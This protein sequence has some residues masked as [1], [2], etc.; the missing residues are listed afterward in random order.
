[1]RTGDGYT[2]QEPAST[3]A[4]IAAAI[5]LSI[6]LALTGVAAIWQQQR[7]S[8]DARSL[9]ERQVERLRGDLA[10]RLTMPAYGLRGA[11][12]TLAALDGSFTRAS[13]EAYVESRE[14]ASEF[15]GARGFGFI[16]RVARSD[17]SAFIAARQRKGG[18]GFRV[19][20]SG[21]DP[22]LYVVTQI[23]PFSRNFAAW[24]LDAGGDPTRRQAIEQAIATGEATLSAPVRLVQDPLKG[25]GLLLFV[26]IYREGHDPGTPAKRR[27]A[28]TGLLYAPLVANELL[29]GVAEPA[30]SL[31]NLKLSAQLLDGQFQPLLAMR[32]GGLLPPEDM[33]DYTLADAPMA[34]SHRFTV[35]GREFQLDVALTQASAARL[36]GLAG[37]GLVV[38]GVLLSLLLAVTVYLLAAGRARAERMARAMTAD[39]ARL[40]MVASHTTNAVMITDPARRITWVNEG[41]TRISGYTPAE[42]LGV[43]PSDLLHSELT[44]ENTVH[45][46][47]EAMSV[48]LGCQVELMHRA[49][50][51]RDYWVD[52]EIQ[53]LHGDDG[54]LSG[55][56]FI[57]SDITAR[58]TLQAQADEAR[59]SLLD[60]YDNAPC[61]YYAL[62]SHGRF[63][64]I[65][66]LGQKWLGC[67]AEEL[68]G[69]ASP[70][71]FFSPESQALFDDAFPRFK[72]D[73]RV[74]E[75]EFDLKGRHGEVRRV[76]LSA[77]AIYAADGS[78]LRSRS[79]MFDITETHRIR[80]QLHQLT[81]NQEAMLES[82]L[83]GIA[84]MQERKIVWRNAALERMFGYAE[85][86]L[87][88][89]DARRLY[90]DD[91][92]YETL[93]ALAYPQLRAGGRF[94]TQLQM[95]RRDGSLI[96][97]DLAGV[98]LPALPGEPGGESLWMMVDITQSKAHE[99]RMEHAALHDALTGLPNRL[100][101]AD[102]LKQAIQGSERSGHVFALA[103]LDLNGFKQINDTHGHD[104]G[105]E[106]LKAVAARLQGGLRAG[107]TV[108]RLGG[109]EFVVLLTL[110]QVP[111]EA[112]A[113]LN[114]L[115]DALAR[116]ITLASGAQVAVGSSLGLAHYP[117]DGR[118]ADAL[119]RHADEAMFANKRAG[120]PKALSR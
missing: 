64:Q 77:T 37:L 73:G 111:G 61:A 91:T 71:D 32:E 59:Q 67:T 56:L 113:V 109:D 45:G 115:L 62:D 87:L 28:L 104:A 65:N 50:S 17:L 114:R 66:A 19:H 68:I 82:D 38:G 79:V 106:V 31:L 86:E 100:L 88:G 110:A 53:P 14:L 44:D 46:M 103:Y 29:Q 8:A 11:R 4:W 24:G 43:L 49:K 76:S 120:R 98:E 26:P 27:E 92:S 116:P 80:Q 60:L 101:L 51:G 18:T 22:T 96:W 94:R 58:K 21:Q 95:R 63:L 90:V 20:G 36:L 35:S 55:F 75:L 6:G 23:S 48:G 97:V 102:R 7:A 84:K 15:P 72:R 39:L 99:A 5:V 52:F 30:A 34:E 70:R 47:R 9:Q 108:A 1:M 81:L 3:T 25:P 85:G 10:E 57:A 74:S 54:A 40:A 42:A 117:L 107:D 119:M 33:A 12:G 78:Y 2:G 69:R 41:F 118:T 83:I 13:F 112:G 93:G 16:E 105:D 89:T